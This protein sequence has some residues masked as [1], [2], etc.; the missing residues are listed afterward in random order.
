VAADPLEH[1]RGVLDFFVAIVFQ[2]LAQ[3]GVVGGLDAC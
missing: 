1:H 2:D 3:P